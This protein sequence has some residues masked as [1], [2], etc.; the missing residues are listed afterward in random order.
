MQPSP[1]PTTTLDGERTCTL[2]RLPVVPVVKPLHEDPAL[3]VE[4]T[5]PPFP[6]A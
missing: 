1:P 4:S 6:T 2:S 3:L 5:V